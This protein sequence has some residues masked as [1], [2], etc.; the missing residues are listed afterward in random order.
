MKKE[1]PNRPAT[2]SE[3]QELGMR[4]AKI[5]RNQSVFKKTD[6]EKEKLKRLKR[7]AKNG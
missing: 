5:D 3:L 2:D 4:S 6:E 1:Q 7:E